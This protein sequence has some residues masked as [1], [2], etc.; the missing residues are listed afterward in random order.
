MKNLYI[1]KGVH[2]EWETEEEL[3]AAREKIDLADQ[4][5]L[6]LITKGQTKPASPASPA[7]DVLET[8]SLETKPTEELTPSDVPVPEEVTPPVTEVTDPTE[9]TS[10]TEE[11]VTPPKTTKTR[12]NK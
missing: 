1:Y 9:K 12:R 6:D 11:V 2:I 8:T 3:V 5:Y 7:S 10:S 4:D